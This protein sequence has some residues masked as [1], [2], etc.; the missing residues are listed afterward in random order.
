MVHER[1]GSYYYYHELLR[2]SF[3]AAYL[4]LMRLLLLDNYYRI[5]IT[6]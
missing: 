1:I 5:T 2:L 3:N 6:E 4:F